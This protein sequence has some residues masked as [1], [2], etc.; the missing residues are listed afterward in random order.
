MLF[1]W[2]ALACQQ[3]VSN[4]TLA[5]YL[6]SI[7]G[8]FFLNGAIPLFYELGVETTYPIAEGVT[9]CLLTS[10]NNIGCLVFLIFPEIPGLG[11]LLCF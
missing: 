10:L 2:F 3:Y 1:L 8:G 9:T 5:L 7:S 4:S 11:T 6:S